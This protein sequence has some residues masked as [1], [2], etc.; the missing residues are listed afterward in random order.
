MQ[1]QV[2]LKVI[3]KL[4]V[5]YILMISCCF[6]EEM[7]DF[8][9]GQKTGIKDPFNMRDPFKRKFEAKSVKKIE[10]DTI[11]HGGVFSDISIVENAD[12]DKIK[13]VGIFMGKERRAMAEV[14]KGN[15]FI[16]REGMKLVRGTAEL[17]AIMPGG[18]ALVEKIKNIYDQ[19]E[20]IETIIP[21]STQ[22]DKSEK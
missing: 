6:S 16:L 21:L 8:F 17:K 5:V 14:G 20:Y 22:P 11:R 3:K 1:M 19:E 12:L 9:G 15:T 10:K 18:I 2:E 13:I 4:V 7:N